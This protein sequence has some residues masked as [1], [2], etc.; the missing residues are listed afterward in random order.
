M[1]LAFEQAANH[2]VAYTEA[3]LS[4]GRGHRL[5]PGQD[6]FSRSGANQ[7][8]IQAAA[9]PLQPALKSNHGGPKLH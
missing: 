4:V 8:E 6:V 2:A 1:S 7:K 5:S 9:A 3:A